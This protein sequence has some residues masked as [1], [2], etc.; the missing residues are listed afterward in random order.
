MH[1]ASVKFVNVHLHDATATS[2]LFDNA[3][4]VVGTFNNIGFHP[5][6]NPTV[7]I[8]PVPTDSLPIVNVV[9]PYD[10][11]SDSDS[12]SDSDCVSDSDTEDL[13]GIEEVED[14]CE[15]NIVD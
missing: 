5:A 15:V 11:G 3:D 9:V 8:L 2:P 6:M 10:F 13:E 4:R 14:E 12:D 7:P 1:S